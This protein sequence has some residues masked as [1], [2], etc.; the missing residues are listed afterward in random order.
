MLTKFNILGYPGGIYLLKIN[1]ANTRTMCEVYSKSTIK[2]PERCQL[3]H[4]SVFIAN[5][6]QILL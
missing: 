5:F 6:E 3:P 2:T 1:D 4:S